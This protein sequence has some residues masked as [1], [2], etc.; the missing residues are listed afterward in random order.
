MKHLRIYTAVFFAFGVFAVSA[1]PAPAIPARVDGG[2]HGNRNLTGQ[3]SGSVSDSVLGSGTALANFAGFDES[4]GGYFG[5]TFGSATYSNASSAANSLRGME[6]AFVATIAST[7]CT[8]S[9]SARYSRSNHQLNGRYKAI[10]GCAGEKGAFSLTQQC[11]YNVP[12]DVR[13]DAGLK[14]C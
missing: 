4:L 14:Q 10:D 13:I 8:F 1:G 9:F 12:G 11:F 7:A 2:G 6:G 5:F 3:Y